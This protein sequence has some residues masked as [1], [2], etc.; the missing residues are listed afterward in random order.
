MHTSFCFRFVSIHVISPCG[1]LQLNLVVGVAVSDASMSPSRRFSLR[2][3]PV[4]VANLS[5]SS[6]IT[7]ITANKAVHLH[8]VD[9]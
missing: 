6:T 2:M 4:S 8:R 1:E 3:V 7:A 5:T 9:L